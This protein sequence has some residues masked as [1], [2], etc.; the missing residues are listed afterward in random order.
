MIP[1]VK[2]NVN[3]LLNPTDAEPNAYAIRVCLPAPTDANSE[4][5]EFGL[6]QP[7]PISSLMSLGDE[8]TGPPRVEIANVSIDGVPVRFETT[9]AAKQG[10]NGL[11]VP[12]E[13][14]SG[15]EWVSWVKVFVVGRGGGKLVVDYIV[16]AQSEV[17]R[18]GKGKAKADDD[19][20][21]F[22]PTFSLPVGRLQVTVETHSGWCYYFRII[23]DTSL[24][25]PRSRNPFATV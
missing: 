24:N 14:M 7:S 3:P 9:A 25:F 8:G 21:I 19:L 6:A 11:G 12:F 22:L 1:S 5:L 4:W 10:Q 17:K 15:K 20:N 23:G 18:Q 13:E 16:K 2:V